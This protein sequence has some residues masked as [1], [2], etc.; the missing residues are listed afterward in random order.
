MGKNVYKWTTI[1]RVFNTLIT[2]A[3]NIALARMLTPYDFGLLAMVAIFSAVA[4]N[5][6][7]CGMSDGIIKKLNPTD[8]DYQTLFTF[9]T[10]SGIIFCVLFIICARPI[11]NFFHEEKLVGIMWAIGIC[12]VFQTMWYIQ[13]TRMRKELQ[14]KKIALVRISASASAVGLGIVLAAKG[15]SYWGL[16]SCRVFLSFFQLVYYLIATRWIPKLRFYRD[17]FRELFGFGV[18]L[19]LSYIAVQVSF[20]INTF[21]LGRYSSAESGLF[22]QAQKMEDVPFRMIEAILNWPFFAVL[23]NE[24]RPEQ[25]RLMTKQML[26]TLTMVTVLLAMFL[27]ILATPGFNLLFGSKWDAAIPIFRILIIFGICSTLKYFFQTILK[28]H[29]R[30]DRIRNLTFLEVGIQ[31]TLLVIFYHWGMLWIAWTQVV[32]VAVVLLIYVIYVCRLEEMT[33][34][35]MFVTSFSQLL[36]PV[37][38]FAIT[39]TGYWF[40]RD[41]LPT[42]LDCLTVIVVF[43]GVAIALFEIRPVPLYTEIKG[44]IFRKSC[45]Q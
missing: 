21:V 7:S 18:N 41:V 25:R 44:K 15:Y 8:R 36:V 30:T 4:Y 42:W 33:L 20:N 40:W 29:T 9:N 27:M 13:E 17:S 19:L 22:S 11:A 34:R 38:A 24:A 28:M 23:S 45:Q 10:V 35:E 43:F 2:T 16:V 31:L 26:S 39:A 37:I 3:G 1:D 6:S 14:M 32:G 12:F 5:I